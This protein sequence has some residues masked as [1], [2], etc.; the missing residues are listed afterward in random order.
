[1]NANL[2]AAEF[3]Q[4]SWFY[5]LMLFLIFGT[6]V[7]AVMLIKKYAKPFR[8]DEKPK[9]DKEIA[10]EEVNRLVQDVDP[11]TQKAMDA[12]AKQME[13]NTKKEAAPSKEEA[14]AEEVSR[15]TESVEDEEAAK[16]MAE[17][18]KAHPEEAAAVQGNDSEKKPESK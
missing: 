1:M 4:Q 2:I 3:Y 11:E 16:A 13:E 7:L 5:I 12:A 8:T 15:V 18:A 17:Y 9:S 14:V 6:I 10:E